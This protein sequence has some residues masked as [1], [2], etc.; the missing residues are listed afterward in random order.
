MPRRNDPL[1]ANTVYCITKPDGKHYRVYSKQM[2]DKL[3]ERGDVTEEHK[4]VL[5][6]VNS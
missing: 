6:R 2:L 5:Q 3:I 1:T 4:V